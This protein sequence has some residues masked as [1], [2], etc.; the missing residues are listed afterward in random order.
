LT[1]YAT[2]LRNAYDLLWHRNG[3]LYVP[4]NGSAAG[5]DTPERP[6]D[7]GCWDDLPRPLPFVP[8]LV[9]VSVR[10]DY[11]VRVEPGRYYGH[12][13]PRRC[14][15]ILNGG[16]PTEGVD[17]GEVE[18]YP[19]GTEPEPHFGGFVHDF[20]FHQS[21]D[22]IVEYRSDV[23]GAKRRGGILVARFSLGNDILALKPDAATGEIVRVCEGIPGLTGFASP[24]DL[25]ENPVTG[26]LYI[27]EYGGKRITLARPLL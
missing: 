14:E 4:V 18:E 7:S 23:F 22:G 17:P 21:P 9:D 16:N 3:C 1:L 5:G 20:G 24:V 13:N 10:R 25:T 12:P 15:Y 27:A 8:A 2:G 6:V 19:V 11:L 26:C